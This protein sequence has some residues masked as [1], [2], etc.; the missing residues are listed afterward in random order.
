MLQY[1]QILRQSLFPPD[2]EGAVGVILTQILPKYCLSSAL[3][4][5][6][7][8]F[9][10]ISVHTWCLSPLPSVIVLPLLPGGVRCHCSKGTQTLFLTP[11]CYLNFDNLKTLKS[12]RDIVKT[13]LSDFLEW[14][15]AIKAPIAIWCRTVTDLTKLIATKVIKRDGLRCHA[16]TEEADDTLRFQVSQ[17]KNSSDL[18]DI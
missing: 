11:K 8:L 10:P 6:Q 3:I 5:P 15:K 16:V 9:S 4:L 12:F 17:G 2:V 14:A 13:F 7:S 1:C 18:E